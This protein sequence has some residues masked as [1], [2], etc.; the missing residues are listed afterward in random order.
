MRCAMNCGGKR[1]RKRRRGPMRGMY[2]CARCGP[3]APRAEAMAY[4]WN[5]P[6]ELWLLMHRR[7]CDESADIN[8][9]AAQ[10]YLDYCA[11]KLDDQIAAERERRAG[12]YNH[13]DLEDY[14]MPVAAI[15]PKV[16]WRSN[17]GALNTA[18]NSL[19]SAP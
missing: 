10:M 3:I 4:R 12:N 11:G 16:V 13:D 14:E 17:Q 15:K 8:Q 1:L 9:V 18:S 19:R 7:A 2:V 5:I 6:V